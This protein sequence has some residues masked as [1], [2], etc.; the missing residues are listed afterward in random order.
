MRI[1]YLTQWFA[2]EPMLIKGTD[3]VRK[4]ESAGHRVHVATGFPNYPGGKIYPGFRI[5]PWQHDTIEGVSIT[6]LPLYPSHDG[7]AVGRALNYL[8]FF[9]SALIY[10]VIRGRNFDLVYVYHPPI[11]V[12]LAAALFAPLYGKP[13][14]I[15]IQDL[16]PD[17]VVASGMRGTGR[18][19]RVLGA[20]C[21]FVYRRATRVIAQSYG[22]KARLQE[23]G[24]PAGKL[25]V[26]RNWAETASTP[27]S[28]V[29]AR[30]ASAPLRLLYAGNLGRVQRLDLV[31]RAIALARSRGVAV[32]LSMIGGGIETERLKAL[33]DEAGDGAV[34]FLERVS[35]GE[36]ARRIAEFDVLLLHLAADPLFTI[37]IPSKTQFYLSTGMPIVA[38]IDGE[39]AQILA[40]SGAALVVP[41]E[42]VEGLTNAFATLAAL[43]PTALAEMGARGRAFYDAELSVDRGMEATLA[44]IA[45]AG[46]GLRG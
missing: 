22:M 9:I 16:W 8:S 36:L 7:S 27:L 30:D 35:V 40:D 26:V 34:H 1:L 19:A 39:A 23:R 3:F 18:I 14:V 2:P 38:G 29:R 17:T 45:A 32:E 21:D 24:V 31:I 33:A 13:F 46:G 12:G 44:V 5:R 4:L 20:L 15:E 42:D 6:R 11:T 43:S 28:E 25:A 41:A 37:T 10:G